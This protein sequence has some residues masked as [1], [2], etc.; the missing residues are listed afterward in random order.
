[1]T[2]V[3]WLAARRA[4]VRLVI[5]VVVGGGAVLLD[6]A[7]SLTSEA[8]V[9]VLVGDVMSGLVTLSG[10]DICFVF[11][12]RSRYF[13]YASFAR[14]CLTWSLVRPVAAIN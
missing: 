7:A 3:C 1:M 2:E 13:S 4:A 11:L 6:G 5:R 12:A 9:I 8:P 14:L 10:A